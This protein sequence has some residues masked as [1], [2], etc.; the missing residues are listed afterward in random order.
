[1]DKTSAKD[2]IIF[3]ITLSM[4]TIKYLLYHKPKQMLIQAGK[5]S[6]LNKIPLKV[7]KVGL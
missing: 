6:G 2:S 5:N 4:Q 3:F 1:M 7:I